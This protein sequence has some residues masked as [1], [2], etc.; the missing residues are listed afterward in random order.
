MKQDKKLITAIVVLSIVIILQW[1]FI[2]NIGKAKKAQKPVL[3]HVSA[4]K[5]AIVLDD[6]GYNLDS[7][8]I[9]N[10]M[11]YPITMSVLPNLSYSK[12]VARELKKYGFEVI[13]HLPMEP[14]EKYHLEKDTVLT[15][16]NES[17]IKSILRRDL[18]NLPVAGVSN[19]MG[20]SATQDLKTMRII[21]EELKKHNLYFL[22]SFVTS[23]SVCPDLAKKMRVRFAKRDIFLDNV[24][25]AQYIMGQIYKLK[26]RAK[27]YGYAIGIGHD[28]KVT[29]EVLAKIMPQLE[30]EGYKFVFVSQ[31]VK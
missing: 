9:L 31:L 30:K 17:Q 10:R 23:K 8:P 21:F 1:I 24:E 29:L 13:L 15:W 4:G 22:D 7:L 20:S 18:A 12:V 2:A 25:E 26:L 28:R 27:F 3:P 5:I 11:G 6:W 14:Q 16:M 19:H